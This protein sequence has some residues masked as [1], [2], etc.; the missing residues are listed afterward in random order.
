M[1]SLKIK[2]L[3][4]RLTWKFLGRYLHRTLDMLQLLWC[5]LFTYNIYT[6]NNSIVLW[7]ENAINQIATHVQYCIELLSLENSIVA[8]QI[9]FRTLIKFRSYLRWV[10]AC[11][12]R[13][14]LARSVKT[15]H[16]AFDFIMSDFDKFLSPR[17]TCAQ[18][19][20]DGDSGNDQVIISQ[21]I[22]QN[23]RPSS[24][25][26]PQGENGGLVTKTSKIKTG[27]QS[28]TSA[29]GSNSAAQLAENRELKELILQNLYQEAEG[30]C[31]QLWRGLHWWRVSGLW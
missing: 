19:H 15:V 30:N 2:V 23:S 27:K 12:V 7:S 26:K 3:G 8:N 6:Y 29:A 16:L 22:S 14:P 24:A 1:H 17:P 4:E 28:V 5:S 9:L 11:A 18:K 20:K 31:V 13:G 25:K 21:T 10:R